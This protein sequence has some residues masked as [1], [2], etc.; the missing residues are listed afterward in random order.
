MG[1]S[2][3]AIAAF[4]IAGGAAGIGDAATL[5]EALVQVS[6]SRPEAWFET[7]RVATREHERIAT[8]DCTRIAVA[9]FRAGVGAGIR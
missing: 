2:R 1:V 8:A 6:D 7:G 5:R 4:V 3:L 9:D